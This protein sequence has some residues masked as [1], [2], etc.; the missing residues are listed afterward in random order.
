[1]YKVRGLGREVPP[2]T[3]RSSA[4]RGHLAAH[5]GTPAAPPGRAGVVGG[6]ESPAGAGGRTRRLADEGLRA[7]PRNVSPAA[8]PGPLPGP[9]SEQ[10]GRG[11]PRWPRA[12]A[13]PQYPRSDVGR[14]SQVGSAAA[15]LFS[16]G[17]G[18]RHGDREEQTVRG[19]GKGRECPVQSLRVQPRR[20]AWNR[21]GRDAFN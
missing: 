14:S 4:W 1:M 8:M 13:V 9:R 21:G 6:G 5:L 3:D 16:E 7:K 15:L 18:R 10:Q 19:G 17:L 20:A 11:Q 2:W 12:P